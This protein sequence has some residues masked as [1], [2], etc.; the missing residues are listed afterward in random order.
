MNTSEKS[1]SEKGRN[2]ERLEKKVE[3]MTE[4][5]I[6]DELRSEQETSLFE[7]YSEKEEFSD[8]LTETVDRHLSQEADEATEEFAI[9]WA[10]ENQDRIKQEKGVDMKK[11]DLSAKLKWCK[12]EGGFEQLKTE[13]KYQEQNDEIKNIHTLL[14][15]LKRENI[16]ADSEFLILNRLNRRI[17]KAEKELK[18]AKKQG[19]DIEASAKEGEIRELLQATQ[20]ISE[21]IAKSDLGKIAETKGLE[22]VIKSVGEKEDYISERFSKERHDYADKNLDD[23]LERMGG[24]KGYLGILGYEIRTKGFLIKKTTITNSEGVVVRTFPTPEGA[25]RFLRKKGEQKA[26]EDLE[27]RL[28]KEIDEDWEGLKTAEIQKAIRK[29]VKS[30]AISPEKAEK[31]IESLYQEARERLVE[32][33]KEKKLK[34]GTKTEKKEEKGAE[35]ESTTEEKDEK[36]ETTESVVKMMKDLLNKEGD[37]AG[38]QGNWGSDGE[39]IRRYCESQ[40]IPVDQFD[41][42]EGKMRKRGMIYE[43]RK[44]VR[45]ASFF[46]ELIYLL[47]QSAKQGAAK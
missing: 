37:F 24:D 38:L 40:G 26:R 47:M 9:I 1:S 34:E 27:E 39:T 11:L 17:E 44:G 22:S 36:G 12:E 15:D 5:E 35:T 45:L 29:E 3:A 13:E 2:K 8:E 23:E 18:Q 21:K 32:E 7:K 4:E 28:K 20:E 46:A 14:S 33:F 19:K 6:F 43:K 31:G 16:P 30:I 42:T 25:A 41:S 10:K